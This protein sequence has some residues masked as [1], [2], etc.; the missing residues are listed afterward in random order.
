MSL[1]YY[2]GRVSSGREKVAFAQAFQIKQTMRKHLALMVLLILASVVQTFYYYPQLPEVIASHFNFEGSANGWQSKRA[3]FGIYSGVLILLVSIFS[4]L[5]LFLDRIPD[6]LINLPRKEYW[7]AP[8]RRAETFSFINAQMLVYG[9]ATLGFIFVVFQLAIQANLTP[10]KQLPPT[11]MLP[12][13]GAYI[14]L[15]L[16][17]T[18]RFIRKFKK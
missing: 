18:V 4:G 8:E 17:W 10:Q 3:L 5:Q 14:L 2:A 6:S 9:N 12:L 7:L 16:V 11:T 13:L 15:F 1:R